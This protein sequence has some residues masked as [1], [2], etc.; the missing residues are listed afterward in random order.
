MDHG[1]TSLAALGAGAP[2][3]LELARA[4]APH[5]AQV[6]GADVLFAAAESREIT[7]S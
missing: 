7:P 1:V 5:F 3:P 4:A 2:S 6:F